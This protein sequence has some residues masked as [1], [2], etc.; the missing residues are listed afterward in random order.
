MPGSPSNI[1]LTKQKSK[2]VLLFCLFSF[3]FYCADL[4]LESEIRHVVGM[5]SH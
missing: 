2:C 5:I 4:Y 1:L 3:R